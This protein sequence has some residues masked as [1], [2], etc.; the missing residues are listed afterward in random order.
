MSFTTTEYDLMA[1]A[2]MKLTWSPASNVALYGSTNDLA[3]AIDAGL[4]I[5]LAP[6]W[7]MGGSRNMLDEMRFAHNWDD[8]HYGDILT[9]KD[10]VEMSTANAAAVLALADTI[11]RLEPGYKA[12]LFVV[13]GDVSVPYDALVAANATN[14]A[15]GDGRRRGAVR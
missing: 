1:A 4:T 12:D 8:A 13:G 2:G 11:G 9:T 7:S 14:G 5:S 10:I 3:L 6:D 15:S